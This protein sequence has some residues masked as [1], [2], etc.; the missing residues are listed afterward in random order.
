MAAKGTEKHRHTNICLHYTDMYKNISLCLIKIYFHVLI[1]SSF[2]SNLKFAYF[3]TI[4]QKQY[5]A[6]HYYN[7]N[8]FT[9]LLNCTFTFGW[10]NL[11]FKKPCKIN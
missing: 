11:Q 5:K 3:L 9:A 1:E 4:K 6:T 10:T 8:S 2:Y 7:C